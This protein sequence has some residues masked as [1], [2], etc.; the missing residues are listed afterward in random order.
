MTDDTPQTTAPGT[1][2]ALRPEVLDPGSPDGAAADG[3]GTEDVAPEDRLES[4]EQPAKLLRIGSMVKQLLE[5]V[6]QAPLDEASR[7]RSARSTS[8]RSANWPTAS[9]RSGGRARPGL[10]PLRHRDPVRRRAPHRPRAT[11]RLAGGPLPRDPGH[12]GGPAGGGPGPARRDAPAVTDRWGRP[13]R[14]SAR[15]PTCRALTPPGTIRSGCRRGR[16]CGPGSQGRRHLPLP[17]G[18]GRCLRPAT[19]GRSRTSRGRRSPTYRPRGVPGRSR[20][21]ARSGAGRRWPRCSRRQ[22]TMGADGQPPRPRP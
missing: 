18:W 13:V 16:G 6:R 22:A 11:G 15:S 7:G 4:I 19:P 21:R 1:T 8:S 3:D 14:R 17:A 20:S 5:E 2:D 12:S 10:H 9:R